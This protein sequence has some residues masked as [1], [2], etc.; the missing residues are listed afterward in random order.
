M[1]S[2]L[3]LARPTDPIQ[4]IHDYAR[5]LA[6]LFARGDAYPRISIG[7]RWS[8][9]DNP[10]IARDGDSEDRIDFRKKWGAE[11]EDPAE[12]S[13]PLPSFDLLSAYG[14]LNVVG[15]EME[16]GF[17]VTTY[18]LTPQALKLLEK[19]VQA[20]GVFIS[21]S[22]RD[23][24]ALALLIEARLRIVGVAEVFI[25]KKITAG[26]QWAEHLEDR[27]REARFFICL[28]GPNTL[29]SS[30]VRQELDW[31]VQAGCR[32]ISIWHGGAKISESA[33]EVLQRLHA[34]S[35]TGESAREYETAISELLNSMGYRTY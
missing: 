7:R 17:P 2:P 32:I 12:W 11:N 5:D 9:S 23:S 35:V 27:I 1:D 15:T 18:I 16:S 6:Y 31:A 3:K 30:V 14:Y 21:Y 34:I 29:N 4:Q 28:I 20:P 26:D 33:P 22:R 8:W 13:L 10:H 24:S 25:D 19:P